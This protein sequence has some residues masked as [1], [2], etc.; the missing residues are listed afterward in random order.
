MTAICQ[1]WIK[2]LDCEIMVHTELLDCLQGMVPVL[3]AN[4]YKQIPEHVDMQ[5]HMIDKLTIVRRRRDHLFYQSRQAAHKGAQDE[6]NIDDVLPLAQGNEAEAINER[7]AR[8]KTILVNLQRYQDLSLHL[9]R[10]GM[11]IVG[12]L[13][14][15]ITG[16]KEQP[17]YNRHGAA[18]RYANHSGALVDIKS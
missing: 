14:A 12:E 10:S 3:T 17:S 4:D 11:S 18:Q 5:R 16:G 1:E 8:L 13:L 7:R 9:M 15:T 2:H 6:F